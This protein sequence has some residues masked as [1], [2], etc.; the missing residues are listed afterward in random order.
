MEI[1]SKMKTV[2]VVIPT[3]KNRGGLVKSID[4]VLSQDC[5][6]LLEIIVV[7]DNDPSSEF[8]KATASIMKQYEG[9]EFVKYICHEANKNGA[10]ARN[11]GIR[12]SRGDYIAFLDDDDLFLANKLNKQ[13]AYLDNTSNVDA[14]YCFAQRKE[15]TVSTRI[16]EGD[17]TRDILLLQ[18]NFFTPSLMFRRKALETINGFDETFRR[19]QDYDLMLRFFNAG[20]SIGCVPKVLIEIGLNEGENIPKGENL[21]QLKTFFFE[22]FTGFIDKEDART[23]GFKKKVYAK[24]YAGV[25][26]SHIKNGF[27]SMAFRTF[28]TY[29]RYSPLTFC[30]VVWQSFVVHLK[31][32]T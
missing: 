20:F 28:C 22:K 29:F 6:N 15:K 8:R 25:F 27:Y 32:N 3:Y 4:S 9:S 1:L 31:G 16:I 18:S 2:S 30:G 26:L 13:I 14:V 7:D 24:H 17:G 23:P 5:P 11:T 19:H 10:A 21:N 12:A